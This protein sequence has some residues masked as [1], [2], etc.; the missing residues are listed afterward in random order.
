MDG[1]DGG[2]EATESLAV[3][4]PACTHHGGRDEKMQHQRWKLWDSVSS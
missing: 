2:Y 3:G 1:I 4:E